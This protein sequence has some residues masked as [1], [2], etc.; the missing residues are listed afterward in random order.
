[1]D[2]NVGTGNHTLEGGATLALTG[3]ANSHYTQDWVIDTNGGVIENANDVVFEGN[4]TTTN[5]TDTLTKEGAGTFILTGDATIDGGTTVKEGTLQIGDGGVDGTIAGD[6]DL[7]SGTTLIFN[8][9][10]QGASG[11][12]VVYNDIISGDGE[13]VKEGTSKLVLS[14][15]N[16]YSG[17]TTVNDGIL[18]I[19]ADDN[20][21]ATQG[22]T[23][24]LNGGNLELTG[25]SFSSDWV[26]AKDATLDAN[27]PGDV[28]MSGVLSGDGGLTKEGSSALILEGGNTYKGNTTL[29][30]GDLTISGSGALGADNGNDYAGDITNSGGGVITF[31]T[32]S[33]QTL[34]GS[35]LALGNLIK[36]NTNTLILDSASMN[37]D[38][39]TVHEGELG[40]GSGQTLNV[41]NQFETSMGGSSTTISMDATATGSIIADKAVLADGTTINVTGTANVALGSSLILISTA[42]GVTIDVSQ[43]HLQDNGTSTNAALTLDKYQDLQLAL[44]ANDLVLLKDWVWKNQNP[45]NAHGTFNIAGNTETVNFDL[46]N[47]SAVEADIAAGGAGGFA[48]WDGATLTKTGAGELILSGNNDYDGNTE[49]K[50]GTLTLSDTGVL[51]YNPSADADYAQAIILGDSANATDGTLLLNQTVAQTLSGDISGTAG[52]V[53]EK[54]GTEVLT[55]SGDNSGFE[56][57]ITVNEGTLSI[58]ADNNVGNGV[59]TLESDATLQLAAGSYSKGWTLSDTAGSGNGSN[60]EVTDAG[61]TVTLSGDITGAGGLTKIG[62]GTLELTGTND[63]SGATVVDNGTLIGNIATGTDLTLNNS[64]IYDAAGQAREIN[65]LNSASTTTQILNNDVDLK[66]AEGNFSGNIGGSGSLTKTSSGT[67]TLNESQDYTGAT[68]VEEGTLSLGT[69]GATLASSELSLSGGATFDAG[70]S[71][72][73]FDT[74]TVDNVTVGTP[75]QYKGALDVSNGTLNFYVPSDMGN[76]GVMIDNTSGTANV[77]NTEV[78]V[79]ISGSSTALT[80][81]GSIVLIDSQSLSGTPANLVSNGVV[82][83]MQGITLS[84]DLDILTS[85]T[86]LLAKLHEVAPGV[87]APAHTEEQAK[88]LSEGALAGV[89]FVKE[90]GELVASVPET[91]EHHGSRL[92]GAARGGV[93]KYET[94]SHVKVKGGS[95][96]TGLAGNVDDWGTFGAFVEWGKGN[97]DTYNL[98]STGRSVRGKDDIDYYGL[99]LIARWGEETGF[100]ADASLRFGEMRNKFSSKDFLTSSGKASGKYDLKTYYFGSHFTLGYLTEVGE[101]AHDFY[102]QVIYTRQNAKKG[103]TLESSSGLAGETLDFSAINA[104]QLKIGSR[105]YINQKATV[106]PYVGVA[107]AYDFGG[108]AEVSTNGVKIDPPA[109]K[110]AS[111]IGELG[112]SMTPKADDDHLSFDLSVKGYAGK[113]KGVTGTANLTYRW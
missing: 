58:S 82:K 32:S 91:L 65:A 60:I 111:G 26:L 64:S 49:I 5:P 89:A 98:L 73:H 110:G 55:L 54:N 22:G 106:N 96:L 83:A 27:A 69:N 71:L 67:L 39:V 112:I 101:G 44:D 62:D 17:D 4:L 40:I 77:D 36:E 13:L 7:A 74:L 6:I 43:I 88:A 14:G 95:L 33:D 80:S 34:S 108:K 85:G 76:G 28:T 104:A 107:F 103:I 56:G 52:S 42:N 19:S 102:G 23:H 86:Q 15:A 41:S 57:N 93:S 45:G 47:N 38:N 48:N 79:G 31:D 24:T 92:F 59:N 12:D 81:G 21:G 61:D 70:T 94:G 75:A 90:A 25:S 53:I 46:H 63:Y 2:N 29:N 20:I 50:E 68:V 109:L 78:N 8:L 9:E 97:A 10:G 37:A 84:L 66:V 1:E 35:T 87:V 99:G 30:A 100:H 51:G 11:V 18:S 113:R 16:T 72:Q 105:Y 3:A